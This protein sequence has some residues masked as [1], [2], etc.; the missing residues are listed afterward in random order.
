VA[1]IIVLINLE[2]V[3]NIELVDEYRDDEE[4]CLCTRICPTLVLIPLKHIKQM[5]DNND[6]KQLK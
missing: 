6:G 4:I 3:L 1:V 2:K 5:F